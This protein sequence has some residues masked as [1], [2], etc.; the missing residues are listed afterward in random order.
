MLKNVNIYV[1]LPIFDKPVFEIL[2]TNK[3]CTGKIGIKQLLVNI[4]KQLQRKGK[5]VKLNL[6]HTPTHP[7][8]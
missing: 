3:W 5:Y 7:L 1:A 8:L 4:K 6:K 2:G